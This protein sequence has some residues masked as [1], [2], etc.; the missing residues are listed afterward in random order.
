MQRIPV[1]S[2][3]QVRNLIGFGRSGLMFKPGTFT[4]VATR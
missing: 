3:A 1:L 2:E 4:L